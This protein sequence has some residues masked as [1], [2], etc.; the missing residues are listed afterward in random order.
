MEDR[1]RTI[2]HEAVLGCG[3]FKVRFPD[4]R[5]SQYTSYWDDLPSRR[6]NPAMLIV[7]LLEKAKAVA[8][9]ARDRSGTTGR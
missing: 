5:P 7:K 2:K 3:S 6:L 4:D 8:R 1:I 9:A